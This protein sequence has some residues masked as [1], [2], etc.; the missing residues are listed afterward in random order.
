[1]N[2]KY[3]LMHS[4][5]EDKVC[6][7]IEECFNEFVAPEYSD[8]G[9][10]EFLK[11]TNP[12]SLR[13][14]THNNHF[15]IVALY[16]GKFIGVIEVRANNHISLLFVKTGYHNMGVAKKLLNLSLDRCRRANPSLNYIDVHSSPYAV[17]VY[18]RLGFARTNEEQEV[19]GIR[20]TPM[21]LTLT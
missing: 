2:I 20:F 19:N 18:E 12:K 5:E 1:M 11:Y 7:L 21:R 3:R 17:K 16:M 15:V 6:C 10:K 14:R 8:A 9:V 4:G 13:N